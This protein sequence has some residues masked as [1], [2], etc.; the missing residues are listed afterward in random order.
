MVLTKEEIASFQYILP[1][2]GSLK[3]LDQVE[4]ILNKIRDNEGKEIKFEQVEIDFLK[5]MIKIL[6]DAQSIKIQSFSL[7]KKILDIK[8]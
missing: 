4:S 7:V 1:V 2:Q 5:V 8:E 6:D 3:T